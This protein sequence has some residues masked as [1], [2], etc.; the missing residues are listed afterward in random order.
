MGTLGI[1]HCNFLHSWGSRYDISN[2]CTSRISQNIS[3]ISAV[4][5]VS[6]ENVG[7]ECSGLRGYDVRKNTTSDTQGQSTLVDIHLCCD[8]CTGPAR[9]FGYMVSGVF[10]N[11]IFGIFAKIWE[12]SILFSLNCWYSVYR[13]NVG[14]F[15]GVLSSVLQWFL[16]DLKIM[17]KLQFLRDLKIMLNL[18]ARACCM[19]HASHNHELE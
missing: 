7:Y 2:Q 6:T 19:N 12:L 11:E 10:L 13:R 8:Q 3:K 17:K 14:V 15:L 5:E 4:V 16:R 9:G 1:Y 18:H